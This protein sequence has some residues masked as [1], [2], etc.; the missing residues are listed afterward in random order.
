MK[1]VQVLVSHPNV[2]VSTLLTVML[3]TVEM[4]KVSRSGLSLQLDPAYPLLVENN[5]QI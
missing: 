5:F 3:T 1:A 2:V 4:I